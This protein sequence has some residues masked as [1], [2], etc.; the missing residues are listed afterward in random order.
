MKKILFLSLF[1]IGLYNASAQNYYMTSPEG[2]GAAATG[3]GTPTV[4]NTVT[5]TTYAQLNTALT[6]TATANAVVLVSGT[7]DCIYTSVLLTNRTIIGLPGAKLRNIQI[8]IG[9]SPTSAA[10]SCILY[11]KRVLI[12]KLFYLQLISI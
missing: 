11:I 6:S 12:V 1:W 4:F 9:D 8:T 3:A 7:I 2:F 10:N 5:V